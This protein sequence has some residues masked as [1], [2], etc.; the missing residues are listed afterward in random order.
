ML[1]GQT[2]SEFAYSPEER[3]LWI[4]FANEARPRELA[5]EF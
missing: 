5:I 3:L 2:L 1:A 4:R